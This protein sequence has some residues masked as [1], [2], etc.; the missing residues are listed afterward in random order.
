ME[1]LPSQMAI[2]VIT[3]RVRVLRI[4]KLVSFSLIMSTM[5]VSW[6]RIAQK[7]LTVAAL[8]TKAKRKM[9]LSDVAGLTTDRPHPV[10]TSYKNDPA[11]KI[12][13]M[14]SFAVLWNLL[15]TK[16]CSQR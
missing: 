10:K 16:S 8:K 14:V 15:R 9:Y 6:L 11:E 2:S 4:A 7:D 3:G 5:Q 1:A 12:S 13:D